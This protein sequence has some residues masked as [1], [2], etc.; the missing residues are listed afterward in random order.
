M[1]LMKCWKRLAWASGFPSSWQTSK[2]NSPPSKPTSRNVA[3][4]LLRAVSRLFSTQISPC[5]LPQPRL[6][7]EREVHADA[8][9]HHW[10]AV[11]IVGWICVALHIERSV[12]AGN[13]TRRVEALPHVFGS[14]IQPPVANQKIESA[15]CQIFAMNGRQAAGRYR[16]AH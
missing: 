16:R 5:L 13:K 10:P 9:D 1:S 15:V 14:V 11:M 3:H 8:V 12:E 4:A 7:A 2:T 6:Q